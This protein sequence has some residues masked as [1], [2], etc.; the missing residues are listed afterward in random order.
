MEEA[1]TKI[2]EYIGEDPEREELK[3]TP[4]RVKEAYEYLTSG[5]DRDIEDE[6]NGA[7]FEVDYDEMVLEKDVE[8]FSLC[9]HH[10]LPFYGKAHI[11]YIP[12]GKV[13]GLSKLPRIVDIYS[14]RLQ[15]QERM[16]VQIADCIEEVLDP[17]GVAV[18]IDA[19][20]LCMT[21]RGVQKQ[22]AHTVTSSML[23]GFRSDART[24]S[25]F[26]ELIND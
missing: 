20:H 5:Y 16:T 26:M 7:V 23:G 24:R 1:V 21:M 19:F 8:V 4:G 3:K 18:V 22:N 10:M 14:R 11:A 2:L 15:M 9:E 6:L 12:D 17:W 13:I 25:E